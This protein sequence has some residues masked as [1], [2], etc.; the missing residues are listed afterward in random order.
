MRTKVL[1]LVSLFGLLLVGAGLAYAI[2]GAAVVSYSFGCASATMQHTAA[3]FDRNNTGANVEAYSIVITDGAGNIVFSG[4]SNRSVGFTIPETTEDFDYMAAPVS[5]PLRLRLYSHAGN[6]LPEQTI[7]D[8][9]G[10]SPCLP[11]S[12]ALT[13]CDIGAPAGSVLSTL[14]HSTPAY[15][16]ADAGSPAGFNIPA[17]TWFTYETSGDFTH[18]FVTCGA[19]PVWVLTSAL[20]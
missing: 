2:S 19:N 5:N 4:T 13:H 17:G 10:D 18:L 7:W 12:P 16:A 20:Q 1:V 11:P 3:L 9:T 14:P 6:G 8:L 15:S